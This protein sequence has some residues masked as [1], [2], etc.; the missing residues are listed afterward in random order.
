MS[1]E[2]II[3]RIISD[4]E[5]EAGRIVASSREKAEGLVR[6]AEREAA[7]RSAAF[8]QEAERE[9]SFRA[10]QIMAQ[11]RLEKKIALLRERRDLLEKALRKAFSQAAPGEIRLKRQVVVRD[12]IREEDFNRE[13]LLEELRPRLEKDIVE[14]LKI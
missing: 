14:A 1:L 4:A 10:N 5:E 6:E 9:A 3:E 12:G 8:L 13:R 11:A 2:K 7:E